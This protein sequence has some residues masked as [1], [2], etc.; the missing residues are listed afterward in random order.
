MTPPP[1]KFEPHSLKEVLAEIKEQKNL[2][3]GFKQQKLEDAWREITGSIVSRYTTE[4]R[5]RGNR[6][7][8]RLSSAPLRNE[9]SVGKDQLLKNLQEQLPELDIKN[10]VLL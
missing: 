1:S 7:Y 5:W 2:A 4:V 10:I 8:V 3:R 6:I 9:L